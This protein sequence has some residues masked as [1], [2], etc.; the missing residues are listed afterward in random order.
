[1]AQRTAN[2]IVPNNNAANSKPQTKPMSTDSNTA[3]NDE[4]S[5]LNRRQEIVV[6]TDITDGNH[7]GDPASH[8]NR[9]RTDDLTD[10]GIMTDV[11]L[12]R[13]LRDQLLED[14]HG[15]YI[16]DT[17]NGEEQTPTRKEMAERVAAVDSPDDIDESFLDEFLNEATDVRYFGATFAFNTGDGEIADAMIK[18]TPSSLTGPFQIG[19][20]KTIHKVRM[21]ENS[22]NLTSVIASDNEADSGGY[23]LDDKRIVYGLFG[24]SGT[25]NEH[26]AAHTGLTQTDVERLD[27]LFWRALKN[28]ANSR[29]KTTQQP[30]VYL[31]VEYEE[32]FHVGNLDHTIDLGEESKVDEQLT[33]TADAS[34]DVSR[35]IERLDRVGDRIKKLHV[36]HDPLLTL[37]GVDGE[38]LTED[39][40]FAAHLEAELG[41][42]V[43]DI[44]VIEE[45]T[46]TLPNAAE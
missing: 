43:H 7:N 2:T 40:D 24:F 33:T 34:A 3:E 20:G 13:Y 18:H 8:D 4:V 21:N 46:E 41:V 42:D 39:G 1:M 11:S 31:R 12:K 36:N 15:V 10:Q 16:A 6:L 37:E 25:I 5:P 28:Q 45:Y 26:N 14:G 27:T 29:S 35:L 17:S 32:G 9:P 44:D 38:L 30:R 23:M 19:T 22:D